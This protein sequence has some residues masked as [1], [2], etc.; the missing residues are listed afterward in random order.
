MCNAGSCEPFEL[1]NGKGRLFMAEVDANNLYYGGD[2][3]N[4]GRIGKDG[5]NDTILA[6]AGATVQDKEWCYA[7]T[8]AGNTV[9]WG[10][11]WVQP[12]VRGCNLPD[13]AGGVQT[14]M[15]GMNLYAIAYDDAN[16][17]L[18]WTQGD[19]IATASWPGGMMTSF[20]GAAPRE[21]ATDGA[22]VYWA[23]RLGAT[24][25]RLR[26][27]SVGG[28]NVIELAVD[29]PSVTAIAVAPSKI[30]WAETDQIVEA[31]LPN[32]IGGANPAVFADVG[33]IRNIVVDDTHV[34][35]TSN[36][37]GVGTVGRCPIAG[38]DGPPEVVAQVGK[39]WGITYDE[40]AVYFVT[41]NGFI[42]KWAK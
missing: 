12:G 24:D 1:A 7:S 33:A 22:F 14:F 23:S 10:N 2:G 31:A 18:Y 20:A 16:S 41:E 29:R 8:K 25:Y 11:D 21:L 9:V 37:N 36:D 27:R 35:W 38:C 32:G 34:Y 3:A 17:R 28:G 19:N 4:V 30:I 6:A 15:P 40:A 26:K 13:C 5:Q 39:P 42:F